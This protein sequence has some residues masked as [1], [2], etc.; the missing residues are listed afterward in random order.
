MVTQISCGNKAEVLISDYES[1][2]CRANES[3]S[4][5]DR[6]AWKIMEQ[7]FSELNSRY[8]CMSEKMCEAERNSVNRLK[9]QFYSIKVKYE[10]L[11]LKGK[12]KNSY[13][14][15]KGFVEEMISNQYTE[16]QERKK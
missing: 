16:K 4:K 10:A 14:A 11:Q 13:N 3:Y 6:E 8:S 5:C 2:V 15:V 9:G 1:L 12:L 7:K